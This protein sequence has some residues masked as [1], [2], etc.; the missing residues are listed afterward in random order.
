MLKKYRMYTKIV[1]IIRIELKFEEI[2]E[3]KLY[4]IFYFLK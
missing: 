1:A 2:F 4:F 3:K